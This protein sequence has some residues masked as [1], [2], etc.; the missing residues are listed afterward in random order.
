LLSATRRHT[1]KG[2]VGVMT[3]KRYGAQRFSGLAAD[4]NSL[5]IDADL[6]GAIFN[7]TDTL[8][9][10]IFDG[11][12]WNK[13][14]G[15]GVSATATSPVPTFFD[16]FE[17]AGIWNQTGTLNEIS[18]GV[19]NWTGQR[20][21]GNNSLV[22]DLGLISETAWVLRFKWVCDQVNTGLDCRAMISI[23]SLSTG[24]ASTNQDA[25]GITSK[26]GSG[27]D[28]FNIMQADGSNLVSPSTQSGSAFT[29]TAGLVKY[30]QI[31]RTSATTIAM[32][33]F[34]D[35]NYTGTPDT[36]NS[37]TTSANV[38]ALR[39][40]TINGDNVAT[41][42]NQD[43]N[44]TIDDLE[45]YDGVISVDEQIPQSAIDRDTATFWLSEAGV[46]ESITLDMGSAVNCYGLSYFID[47][48]QTGITETQFQ[49]KSVTTTISLSEL[50]AYYKYNGSSTPILNQATAVGS[51]DGITP[52]TD[53]DVGMV[54]GLFNQTGILGDSV[55][56]NGTSDSGQAG[57]STSQFNFM[58]NTSMNWTVNY[59]YKTDGAL[60]IQAI[61]QLSPYPLL[62]SYLLIMSFIL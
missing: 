39:Y 34:S 31:R 12:T 5:P 43:Y 10:W 9:F 25:I 3:I 62:V 29:P 18:G 45:F 38:Q 23:S 27:T 26:T 32:E 24:D 60:E 19:L 55:F 16:N 54:G 28:V 47:K 56:F 11:N 17:P 21:A 13:S 36:N 14:A 15:G 20:Q 50:K 6:I 53:A 52:S 46:N 48:T 42:G 4:V 7:S 49:I 61:R 22:H 44:G 37:L 59:W 57:S 1:A 51:V 8:E 41:G 2:E 35:A 40:I 33:T 58:H 30:I